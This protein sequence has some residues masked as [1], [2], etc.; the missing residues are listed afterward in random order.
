M[1]APVYHRLHAG[2]RA[3]LRDDITA[4]N[5]IV[6]IMQGIVVA[7]SYPEYAAAVLAEL[8][9]EVAAKVRQSARDMVDAFPV[10]VLT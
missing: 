3:H 8:P 1:N 6:A 4:A 7:M 2:W 5:H 10:E 9:D